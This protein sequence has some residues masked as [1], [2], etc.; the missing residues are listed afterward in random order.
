MLSLC[1]VLVSRAQ[2]VLDTLWFR[3]EGYFLKCFGVAGNLRRDA[4]DGGPVH[5]SA[6]V[7]S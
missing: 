4:W 6:C 3:V 7:S 2:L 1:G 5:A